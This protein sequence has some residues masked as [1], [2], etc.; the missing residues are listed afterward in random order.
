[1]SL[2]GCRTVGEAEEQQY[3]LHNG[4][5]NVVNLDMRHLLGGEAAGHKREDRD[6]LDRPRLLGRPAQHSVHPAG[7]L[8]Q[9]TEEDGEASQ[10]DKMGGQAGVRQQ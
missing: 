3:D 6:K 4:V 2:M 1:M 10:Q 7:Q 9:P 5:V 8:H